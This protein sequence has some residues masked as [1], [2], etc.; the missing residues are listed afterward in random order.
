MGNTNKKEAPTEPFQLT[1]KERK[2][3]LRK[4]ELIKPFLENEE[5]LYT[6][7][8]EHNIML[9]TVRRWIACYK[10]SGLA[11][12]TRRKP[13]KNPGKI[14]ACSQ[15]LQKMIEELYLKQPRPNMASVYRQ[16]KDFAIKHNL[17]CPSYGTILNIIKKL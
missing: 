17:R 1:D 8:K 15:E 14:R 2:S 4:Y 16:I 5:S 13:K 3:A 12:L 11:G 6:V 7:C 10:N 9:K